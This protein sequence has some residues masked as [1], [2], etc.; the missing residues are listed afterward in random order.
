M[1]ESTRENRR[2]RQ[3]A[4]QIKSELGWLIERKLR[5]PKKG[6]ITITRVKLSPDLK[7]A[8]VYFSA[9]GSETERAESETTLK[10]SGQFLRRELA[11]RLKIRYV[12]EIRFFFDDSL[13]YAEHINM[14]FKKI[15]GA[16]NSK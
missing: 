11:Q 7:L 10:R 8:N 3:L 2:A 1:F 15:N 5:D 12:P 16:K 14:L 6:F 13:D 9:M 4:D